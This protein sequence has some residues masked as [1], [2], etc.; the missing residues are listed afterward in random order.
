MAQQE[1]VAAVAEL[2]QR[3]TNA[4]AAVLTDY[5]GLTTAELTTLRRSLGSHTTYLVCKNTLAKRAVA[6]AGYAGLD[7]LLVGPT[8]IAFVGGDPVEAA[9]GLRDFARTS[10]ALVIK[11]GL[12]DGRPVSASE[13]GKLADLESREVLLTKLA[14]AMKANLTKAA[15]TFAAPLSKFARL[16]A[17]LQEKVAADAPGAD[18]GADLA[19]EEAQPDPAAEAGAP[20][21]PD[22]TAEADADAP[23]E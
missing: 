8:A 17:A 13:F 7:E 5:R 10:P 2:S 14:G 6:D 18:A 4:S 23:A 19:A 3:L 22:A 20:A 11:G 16:A 9:K 1:K 15:A 12:V 21:Q